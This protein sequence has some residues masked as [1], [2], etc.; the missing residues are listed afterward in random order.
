[1]TKHF[2]RFDIPQNFELADHTGLKKFQLMGVA[3]HTGAGPE[4]G[5]FFSVFQTC[6]HW[7]V[8]DDTKIW[9]IGEYLTGLLSNGA[10]PGFDAT[11]PHMALYQMV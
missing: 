7:L 3:V 8:G 6:K 2:D 10:V 1:V 9:G 11:S 5:H 4:D